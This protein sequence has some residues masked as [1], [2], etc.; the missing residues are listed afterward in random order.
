[1][2]QYPSFFKGCKTSRSIISINGMI[3]IARYL[4]ARLINDKWIISDG[5]SKKF[6]KLFIHKKW[7]DE[8]H[9]DNHKESIKI[10]PNIVHLDDYEKFVG[11][12]GNLVEIEVRGE[13]E[14][15]KCYF[16]VKDIIDG[17]GLKKLHTTIIDHRYN[18]YME[19]IHY[20]YFYSEKSAIGGKN[21]IKKLYLTY[22]GLLRVL[23]ASH[24]NTADKF[25]TWA[26]ETLFVAQM[27]T[28]NQKNKLISNLLG[29]SVEAVKAVFNKTTHKIPCIYLFS[30]GI[31]KKLRKEL[32]IDN[33]YDDNDYVYKWGMSI[34]LE[35][36]TKEHEKS[37]S[38]LKGS[39]IEL[40]LYG[41]IDPQYVSEAETKVKYTFESMDLKLDS[42]KYN[43]LTII[44]KNKMKYIKE[45][46]ELISRTYMGHITE[47]I[48]K[49][50]EK[51]HEVI[52]LKE[53]HEKEL[54]IK[55]NELLK[56]KYEKELQIK[57]NE[58]LKKELEI[59]ILKHINKRK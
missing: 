44:P 53:K 40:I 16:K 26:T 42:D 28:I 9:V 45:Q 25:L 15:N 47:L 19:N 5:K 49:I 33:K 34:D 38:K 35:R 46:Y 41:F 11:N 36:R 31:V 2:N 4:F 58:L 13:R 14:Y 22:K 54:Q 59:I 51:G 56:E 8:N 39:K 43:E 57:E 37:Y 27:G 24:K 55:E 29:V 48:N 10:S 30:I 1:M 3:P 21:T 6:D 32:N 18:G 23:F 17:F 52:F 50:K 7:F 20:K 12:D